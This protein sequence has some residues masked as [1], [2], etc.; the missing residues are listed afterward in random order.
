[1]GNLDLWNK[2]AD[3]DPAEI[4]KNRNA[5]VPIVGDV[6]AVIVD[7]SEALREHLSRLRPPE[8]RDPS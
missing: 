3:I 5:D 1:M 7:L 6:K 2:H 4:G 8:E